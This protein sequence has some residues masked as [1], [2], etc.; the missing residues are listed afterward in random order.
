M[1]ENSQF[2]IHEDE[3][4]IHLK[5][6]GEFDANSAKDVLNVVY[7]RSPMISRIFIH[8]N[9]LNKIH[10]EARKLFQESMDSMDN[11]SI[12][13]IFTGAKASQ[14]APDRKILC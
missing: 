4:S 2:L 14:L 12:P 11:Q 3:G 1:P 13:V 5:V 9:C 6:V 8:T 7:K 10:P